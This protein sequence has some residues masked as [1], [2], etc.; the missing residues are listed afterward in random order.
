MGILEGDRLNRFILVVAIDH[1]AF[2][3]RVAFMFGDIEPHVIEL[4]LGVASSTLRRIDVYFL[5][6]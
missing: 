6:I 3:R 4:A 5:H 2:G 1:A